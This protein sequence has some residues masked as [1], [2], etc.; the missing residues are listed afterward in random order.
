[1]TETWLDAIDR[2]DQDTVETSGQ[3]Y[4]WI[5]WVHG[6]PQLK[7]LGGVPYTGGWFMP[8]DGA[9]LDDEAEIEGWTRGTLTHPNGEETAG[10]FAR[11]ITI[12]LIRSRRAWVV[13][14]GD[15]YE[16]YPWD[17][18]DQAKAAGRPS[19]KLQILA[20]VKNLAAPR[21]VV[22]TMRGSVSRAFSPSRAG[23]TVLNQFNRCVLAPANKL[24]ARAGRKGRYP[25]RAF[26][27]TVGPKRH[28]DGSPVFSTVGEGSESSKITEP[29]AIGLRDK[30]TPQE[31]GAL[32]VGLE[33]L[34]ETTQYWREAEE[35]A[36]AWSRR[37]EPAESALPDHALPSADEIDLPF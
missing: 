31:I 2:I 17:Q 33:V 25:Y 14:D 22:L 5:Q 6:N 30:M 32:F 8:A 34:E 1:M 23:D 37:V 35:W 16:L 13:R 24:A 21:P 15:T 27:L 18:Y 19:G 4:P 29:T 28:P 11:D 3:G 26:W 9:G 36:N 12:A 20:V 7:R 10:W